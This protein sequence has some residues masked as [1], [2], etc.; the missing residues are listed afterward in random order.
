MS[1]CITSSTRKHAEGFISSLWVFCHDVAVMSM[2]ILFTL[3]ERKE[4]FKE[5][6]QLTE[7]RWT[8]MPEMN[9]YHYGLNCWNEVRGCQLHI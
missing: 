8:S 5:F 1:P 4:E 2:E 6:P 9:N 3:R 7:S